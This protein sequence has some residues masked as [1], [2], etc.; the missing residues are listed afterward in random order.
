MKWGPI[1]LP[2]ILDS[3]SCNM[4]YHLMYVW[5]CQ[6][7]VSCLWLIGCFLK[8]SFVLR[9]IVVWFFLLFFF[10]RDLLDLW[11]NFLPSLCCFFLRGLCLFVFCVVCV[12]FACVRFL[13]AFRLYICV[14]CVWFLCLTCVCFLVWFV[15]AFYEWLC[16]IFD[17]R[18]RACAAHSPHS[19]THSLTTQPLTYLFIHSFTYSLATTFTNPSSLARWL[20]HWSPFWSLSMPRLPPAAQQKWI[21]TTLATGSSSKTYRS[22]TE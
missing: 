18:A 2:E 21:Q 14:V 19:P 5:V 8:Y 6:V 17:S 20:R 16:R 1:R 15:I 13:I 12:S 3:S 11:S 10:L 22:H 4:T 7:C 9:C